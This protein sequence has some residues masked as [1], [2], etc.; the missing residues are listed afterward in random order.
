MESVTTILGIM[1]CKN[2]NLF[3]EKYFYKNLQQLG[4]RYNIQVYVFYPNYIDFQKKIIKGFQYNFINQNWETKKFPLPNLIY[5]RCFYNSSKNYLFYKPYIKLLRKQKNIR[6]LGKGLNGKWQ[7]YNIL[8]KHSYFKKHL[9]KTSLYNNDWQQIDKW[10]KLF[11]VILKPVGGT[12]GKGVIKISKHNNKYEVIGR[13]LYCKNIYYQFNKPAKLFE[14]INIFTFN[15]RY[16]IQ[17]YLNLNTSTN[18]PFDI[19]VLVQKNSNGNWEVTGNGARIGSSSNITSNLYSDSAVKP[20]HSLLMQEFGEI[21]TKEILKQINEIATT[22]PT[23]LE[24]IHGHLV[25]LGL[26][27]GIDKKGKVWII[28]VNSKPGRR[29]FALLNNDNITYKSIVQPILYAKYLHKL[30][31]TN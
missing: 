27:I 30:T 31:L 26:D 8:A 20:T 28:E 21:K 9:P 6:F 11:P 25:E 19:R 12:H 15:K 24:S 3:V 23:Y 7:I 17:Q 14:W 10:L 29:L 2:K 13:D 1:V 5:D 16:L 22:L 18:N 4:L